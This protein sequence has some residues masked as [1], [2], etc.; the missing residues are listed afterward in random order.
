MIK[1]NTNS[2]LFENDN[3]NIQWIEILILYNFSILRGAT[4]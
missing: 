4:R 3:W 2:V 1:D